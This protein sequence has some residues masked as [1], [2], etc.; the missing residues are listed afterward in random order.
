MSAET[1]STVSIIDGSREHL[2]QV[3]LALMQGHVSEAVRLLRTIPAI[4]QTV[5]TIAEQHH[6]KLDGTGYPNGLRESQ[7]KELARMATLVDAFSAMTD[8]RIYRAAMTAEQALAIMTGEMRK[9]LDQ[10]LLRV[11]RTILLGAP[12]HSRDPPLPPFSP[13]VSLNADILGL[14]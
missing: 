11:F 6:E 7:L 4:P 12:P 14:K 9:Q 10:H 2:R 1:H 3:A 13:R 8:H 5:L